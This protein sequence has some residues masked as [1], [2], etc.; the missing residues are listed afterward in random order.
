LSLGR[1]PKTPTAFKV[2]WDVYPATAKAHWLET[3]MATDAEAAVAEGARTFGRD[4][5][6]FFAI[7]H[8]VISS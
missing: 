5:S 3:V 4:P 2:R 8:K 7:K 1:R 6:S